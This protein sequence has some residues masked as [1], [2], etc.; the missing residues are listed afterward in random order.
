MLRQSCE[1]RNRR[2]PRKRRPPRQSMNCSDFF[3]TQSALA[4][5]R[6]IEPYGLAVYQSSIYVVAAAEEIEDP[7][8]RLRHWKLDRFRHAKALDEYFKPDP[9]IDLESHLGRSIGIFSGDEPTI[10]KIRL[11]GRAAAWV[12]EDPWHPEQ[13]IEAQADGT[14]ILSVPAS[15]PRELLPKVLSLASDAEVIAPSSFRD[16]IAESV[17]SM[18]EQ[19]R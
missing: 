5:V 13:K 19:Y 7:A 14:S 10:V 1:T 18:A 17:K 16:T 15:H 6:K 11:G 4:S 3:D 12:R 2:L 9:S 8:E